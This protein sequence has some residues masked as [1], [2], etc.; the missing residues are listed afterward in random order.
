MAE[1]TVF[2][3]L[4][5]QLS[6]VGSVRRELGRALP[7]GCPEGCATVLALLGH[8]GAMRLGRLAELQNV[9][10]SVTSRHVAQLAMQGWIERKPDPAD[11]RSRILRL[12]SEGRARLAEISEARSRELAAR[13]TDWS[14]EDVLGLARLLARLR[15]DFD[16]PWDG[17]HT[18]AH[19][20]EDALRS[21]TPAA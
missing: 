7:S 16:T 19:P 6:A 20:P 9:D 12:T 8:H 13:L 18:Y 2:A 17:Q 21:H 1:T 11:R 4:L 5:R 15:A 14:N 10:V 3:E